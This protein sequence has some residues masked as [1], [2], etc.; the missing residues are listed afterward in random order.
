M[1]DFHKKAEEAM[2]NRKPI[3]PVI[4]RLP[5]FPSL[6]KKKY[7]NLNNYRIRKMKEDGRGKNEDTKHYAVYKDGK[8][9]FSADSEEEAI[10]ELTG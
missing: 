3:K 8:F 6:F 1:Y 9:L 4:D 2:A 10:R 7:V 5:P